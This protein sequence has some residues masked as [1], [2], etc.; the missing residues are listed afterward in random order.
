MK[1]FI[2]SLLILFSVNAAHAIDDGATGSDFT[3]ENYDDLK[4][5]LSELNADYVVLE[6]A[7][8][9]CPFVRRHA[10]AGTMKGLEEKYG[11]K[12][13]AW[14]T[15]NSTHFHGKEDNKAYAEKYGLKSPVLDD[16]EGEVGQLYSATT[17]P[18]IFVLD[19]KRKVL[20]QGAVDDDPYGDK[21]KKTNYIDA[22]LGDLT[23]GK[24]LTMKSTKPY[25]CSVKYK[26]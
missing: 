25:G 16:H 2:L 1:R 13:V 12:G 5:K 20:Y 23:A 24:E 15:I 7:N 21:E 10:Q 8:P 9:K 14:L 6:W 18:H 26:G 22:V 4:V 3:L 19:K 17:T 11:E